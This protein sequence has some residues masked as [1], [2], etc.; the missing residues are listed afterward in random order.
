MSGSGSVSGSCRARGRGRARVG[1]GLGSGSDSCL[2]RPDPLRPR[3]AARA[4]V[5][6]RPSRPRFALVGGGRAPVLS[7]PGDQGSPCCAAPRSPSPCVSPPPPAA[8]PARAPATTTT[9]LWSTPASTPS[10]PPVMAAVRRRA[11]PRSTSCSSSTT[12]GRWP[13]SRP[14]WPPTSADGT[15]AGFRRPDAL[16]AV[17]MLTDENDCSYEQ[18]VTLGF[19]E[20]LCESQMEPPANYVTFLD[21]LTGE[22]GRWATAIIAGT[23]PGDVQLDL[24]RRRLRRAPGAV[25]VLRRP[26]QRGLVVDLRRRPDRRPVGRARALRHRLPELPAHRPRPALS[27]QDRPEPIRTR[28]TARASP[29]R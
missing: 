19:S 13:R 7:A 5:P 1:L 3:A 14:T 17:V 24:R 2:A 15:N 12:P 11:A 18:T 20:F 6:S 4:P 23:G 25:R 28:P 29:R 16:L 22:R 21:Q 9:T 10:C 26:G 8:R 27:D